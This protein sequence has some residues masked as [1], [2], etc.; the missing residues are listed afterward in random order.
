MIRDSALGIYRFYDTMVFLQ[1]YI[2]D[3]G[4]HNLSKIMY[5]GGAVAKESSWR[6]IVPRWQAVLKRFDVPYF[7][8]AELDAFQGLYKSWDIPKRNEFL[9]LLIRVLNSEGRML[10]TVHIGID[11]DL[12]QRIHS[13]F[14][15]IR[16]TAVQFCC[17][18]CLVAL[19]LPLLHNKHIEG[20]AVTIDRGSRIGA[21]SMNHLRRLI[22]HKEFQVQY[23]ITSIVEA[24]KAMII[25]LQT[26]DLIA[27]EFY[28]ARSRGA[29]TLT[30]LPRLTYTRI[31]KNHPYR[32]GMLS[33]SGIREMLEEHRNIY[34][35]D[36]RDSETKGNAPN[37]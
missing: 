4:S 6:S 37:A 29:Y 2:D 23:K 34:H 21:P 15:Y 13:E 28:R 3:S 27:Y 25:P 9:N 18:Y 22:K 32:G 7:H 12:Y 33:E 8:A 30:N 35:P 5:W 19:L 31:I 24:D 14:P 17:Q 16:L 20:V 26:A 1:A 10:Q 11:K 36:V